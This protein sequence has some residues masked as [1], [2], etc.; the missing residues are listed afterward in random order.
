MPSFQHDHFVKRSLRQ[1]D[2]LHIPS[3]FKEGH[4]LALFLTVQTL[5]PLKLDHQ[6]TERMYANVAAKTLQWN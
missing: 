4:A 1:A 3:L 6:S 5:P 2:I